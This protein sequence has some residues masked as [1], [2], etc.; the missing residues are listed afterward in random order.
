LYIGSHDFGKGFKLYPLG[1]VIDRHNKKPSFS[2][3]GGKG[4]II[5]IPYL[6]KVQGALIVCKSVGGW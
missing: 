6:V 5:S 4:P 3:A 1:E 2:V